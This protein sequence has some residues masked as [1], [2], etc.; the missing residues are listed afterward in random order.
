MLRQLYS[1]FARYHN[2]SI[3]Y[4]NSNPELAFVL[5][6]KAQSY[7]QVLD[8][9][10]QNND[11]KLKLVSLKNIINNTELDIGVRSRIISIIESIKGDIFSI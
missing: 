11:L 9:I 1:T 10:T 2:K 6:T 8:T 5:N 3:K 7:A 4:K